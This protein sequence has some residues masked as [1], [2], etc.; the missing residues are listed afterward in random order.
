MLFERL[1]CARI[2]L[3]ALIQAVGE[4]S[5]GGDLGDDVVQEA[6]RRLPQEFRS[7]LGLL[8]ERLD[9][10][11]GPCHECLHVRHVYN[12]LC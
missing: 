4:A 10:F 2:Q 9:Q 8:D 7:Q 1:D 5:T 6:E 3:V 11:D 12:L